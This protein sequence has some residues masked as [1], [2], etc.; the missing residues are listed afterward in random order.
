MAAL[1]SE[2]D[3]LLVHLRRDRLFEITIPSKTQAYLAVGKPILMG[4]RG[5]AANLI[6]EAGAGIPF[7]PESPE[8]LAAAVGELIALSAEERAK[9]GEAGAE[10]YD[11]YL[12]FEVGM[13]KI[14]K[15]L[16]KAVQEY[17]AQI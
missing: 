3:A 15:E 8:S 12:S 10:Y 2:A 11:N 9:M 7:E 1:F 17:R 6:E 5:D 16:Q 13:G 4:V 14:E